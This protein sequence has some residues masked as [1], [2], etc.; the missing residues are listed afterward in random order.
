MIPKI[1]DYSKWVYEEV[2]ENS[3][4]STSNFHIVPMPWCNQAT[5]VALHTNLGSITILERMTG[6]GWFDVETGYRDPDGKFWLASG[7]C[8][9]RE[10]GV[11][12]IG[13]AIEWI[14]ENSN[15]CR[16]V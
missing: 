1:N 6:Y 12:T 16:G 9:V 2:S 7:M 11:K 10:A 4:F 15:T 14:K 8:D 13:E 5:Q 3:P